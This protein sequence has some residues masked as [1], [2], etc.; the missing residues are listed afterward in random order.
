MITLIVPTYNRALVLL[1]VIDSFYKQENISEVIFVN[2]G[3]NDDTARIIDETSKNYPK[4]ET[5]IFVNSV[6]MGAAQSRNIGVSHAKNEYI[7]FCDDDMY[8]SDKYALICFEKLKSLNADVVSG[9]LIYMRAGET[10]IAAKTRYGNGMRQGKIFW[11]LLCLCR[12]SAIFLGDQKTPITHAVILTKKSLLNAFPYDSMY[13]RGNGFREESDYQMNLF[14]NGYSIYTTNDCCTLHLPMSEVTGGGQ[15][16]STLSRVY[17]SIFYTKYFF[18]K[19]Y[20]SY[21]KR[22]NQKTPAWVALTA[23]S[24]YILYKEVLRPTLYRVYLF[25]SSSKS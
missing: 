2:D 21:A 24:A 18:D 12:N 7:L 10:Q 17:W 3:G 23:F 5:K 20:I 13:S 11:P 8:L 9:R 6:R 1:K 15:R 25:W 22:I 4:I 19:Y 16:A 14:V